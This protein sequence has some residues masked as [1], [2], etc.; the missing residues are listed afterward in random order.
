MRILYGVQA[1]GQGHISR[2]RAMAQAFKQHPDVDVTWLFSGRPRERLFDMEPFGDFQHRAG[3]TFVTEAG[4][5]RY[6][7]TTM[8]NR[9]W[10]FIRDAQRLDV[11]A[12]DL[13]V[14][15]YEPVT[16]WA[17]KLKRQSVLGIGHQYAFGKNTP[18]EGRSLAQHA[19]MSL[20][21]PV[22]RGVGL[23]WSDFGDNVLPPI[24][25]LPPAAPGGVQDLS[26]IHI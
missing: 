4:R 25:D 5:L 11:T 26:L 2:A 21:A 24:L 13:V 17:G 1:T 8:A 18:V 23:H 3:L 12:Y 22:T 16:A 20:F 15:D 7:K 9:Y 10:Q 19:V 14:T 6:R